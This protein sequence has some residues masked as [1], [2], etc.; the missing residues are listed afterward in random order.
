MNKRIQQYSNVLYTPVTHFLLALSGGILIGFDFLPRDIFGYLYLGVAAVLFIYAWQQ[1]LYM[2]FSVLPYLIY[3]EIY[4]RAYD[5]FIPYLFMPYVYIFVFLLYIFRKGT[6]V[7][8]HS[9]AFI[10]LI[11]FAFIEYFNGLRTEDV[12]YARG[13]ITNTSA[14]AIIVFWAS[15]TVIQP[16]LINRLFYHIKIAGV[17]LTGI[18]LAAHLIGHIDYGLASNSESTNGL[19]PV[20][21]SGY[22][23]LVSILFFLSI[24]DET[25]R[26]DIILNIIF[27]TLVTTIM[28]LSFSRGG[29][30]FLVGVMALYF[31]LNYRKVSN[32][33]ILIVLIPI[34]YLIY[35]YVTETTG[36]A[37]VERYQQE[38]ASGRDI[39][40]EAAWHLFQDDPLAGV[41]TGN[42][43]HEIIKRGL[44]AEESGAH[45]EFMRAA[46]E[47]GLLG[48]IFYWGFFIVLFYEV[49]KRKKPQRDYGIY[50]FVL[51][52]LIIVHNGLKIS[53]QPIILML[54]VGTPTLFTIKLRK[55]VPVAKN[56]ALSA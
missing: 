37:I 19:A 36:G 31:I 27:F 23:G 12:D 48:I 43:R 1:N 17:L 42:F 28:V 4:I 11:I 25:E 50:F 44:Y 40:V 7:R 5:R 16:L 54:V 18:V 35:N 49:L 56:S 51:F 53:I 10:F 29:L 55:H 47:H 33:L 22:L 21:I 41:G 8:I 6:Q 46:A 39:L 2:F 45:N 13:L 26:R 30:Y 24:M 14:L 15:T 38:G 20:Q 3:M 52:C 32:Y 9:R 34:G